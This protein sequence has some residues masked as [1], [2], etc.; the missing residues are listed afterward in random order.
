MNMARWTGNKV[1]SAALRGITGAFILNS[2]IGKL[3][4]RGEAAEALQGMA[5]VGVP[6]LAKL[7]PD[8]FGKFISYSEVGIGSALLLPVV[9][10]RLA[11]A[12]L[13]TFGAGLLTIYFNSEGMTEDDGIRPTTEGNDLAKNSWLVAAG[14]ALMAMPKD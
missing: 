13:T 14:I 8:D 7:S 3:G 6:A 4:L 2:G 11:G 10:R 1:A 12:A 9:P 5:A